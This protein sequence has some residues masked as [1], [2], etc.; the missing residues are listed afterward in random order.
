M[1]KY[2][3]PDFASTE[4][5]EE[6]QYEYNKTT[7]CD[8]L[9]IV[10][11]YDNDILKIIEFD[12]GNTL[13]KIPSSLRCMLKGFLAYK[14]YNILPQIYLIFLKQ[15]KMTNYQVKEEDITKV[16]TLLQGRI[17]LIKNLI[18]Q[19]EVLQDK[20]IFEQSQNCLKDC[21]YYSY[22]FPSLS[23]LDNKGEKTETEE[24]EVEETETEETKI[25]EAKE[26]EE[27]KIEEAEVDKEKQQTAFS[28]A[29]KKAEELLELEEKISLLKKELKD[30]IAENNF[31]IEVNN[32]IFEAKENYSYKVS[33]RNFV[34]FLL[35]N[36]IQP[37]E[38][39]KPDTEKISNLI[40]QDDIGEKIKSFAQV[41]SEISLVYYQREK[42]ENK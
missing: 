17:N 12:E 9:N 8:S 24:T 5:N 31:K 3:K 30:I 26:T 29:R 21:P 23:A 32:Y 20:D 10:E 36:G 34:N 4:F 2:K 11:L 25:E 22:C 27:T 35:E 33:G 40:K 28:I 13:Y 7:Y 38:Y 39:I 42:C 41:S 37:L 14:K 18:L 19:Y 16:E 6:L 15:K 1:F